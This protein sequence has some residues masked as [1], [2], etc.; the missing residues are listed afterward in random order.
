MHPKDAGR[1]VNSI[2]PDKTAPLKI[3]SD[4]PHM[5]SAA[6]HNH[7]PC[8]AHPSSCRYTRSGKVI[9]HRPGVGGWGGGVVSRALS[10]YRCAAGPPHTHPINV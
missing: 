8:H 5:H 6:S 4:F 9:I 7:C 10:W 2:D 1:M 3:I